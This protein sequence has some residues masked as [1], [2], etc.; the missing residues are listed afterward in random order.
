MPR[1][2]LTRRRLLASVVFVVVLVAFMYF[3]LP[4]VLG[5]QETWNRITRGNVWWLGVAFVLEIASF[6]GY[7]VPIKVPW[8]IVLIGTLIVLG[9]AMLASLWPAISVAQEEPLALLQ[10][11]RAAA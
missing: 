5:L 6:L 3:V 7:V 4:K 1:V 10:A 9:T 8:G 11:G 2:V